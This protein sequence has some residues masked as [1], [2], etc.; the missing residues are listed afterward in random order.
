MRLNYLGHSAI[1]IKTKK[2]TVVMDPFSKEAVGF[3]M[4]KTAAEIVTCSHDHSDHCSLD[5]IKNNDYF[6][7]KG[8]GEYELHEVFIKGIE[9]F[10][11]VKKGEEKKKNIIYVVGAEGVRVCHLGDLGSPKP[12]V[13]RYL[14]KEN[15]IEK[16][17]GV[18]VLFV[19]VGGKATIGP[20]EAVRVIGQ[21][22]PA[23]AVPI[24]YKTEAH[25][26]DKFG[27]KKTLD[28]FLKEWGG[29]VRRERGLV[30]SKGSLPE[31][32]EVAVL[33]Y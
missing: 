3:G 11:G 22:E 14:A 6:L 20:E 24:H 8:P 28:E 29:G 21:I 5:S 27:K 1:K 13:K 7:I 10:H 32:T 23:I 9:P 17:N 31:E 18:D 19:P 30:V 33:K 4:K 25:R 26:V 16:I 12:G 2:A 15:L